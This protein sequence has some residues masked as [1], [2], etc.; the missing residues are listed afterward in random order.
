[1]DIQG[2]ENHR[3]LI[4]LYEA[5]GTAL[6]MIAL[7]FGQANGLVA[8][9]VSLALFIATVFFS[10]FTGGNFNPAVTIGTLAYKGLDDNVGSNNFWFAM[11]MIFA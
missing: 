5:A 1:M 9:T 6:L 10:P 2:S 3:Y 4:L 8:V 7:N 11:L